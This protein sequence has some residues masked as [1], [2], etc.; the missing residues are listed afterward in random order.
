MISFPFF[1]ILEMLKIAHF[2]NG[3]ILTKLESLPG[4]YDCF[5]AYLKV[6]CLSGR[7]IFFCSFVN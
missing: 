4:Y 3:S 6:D 7:F 1:D 2:L 5:S